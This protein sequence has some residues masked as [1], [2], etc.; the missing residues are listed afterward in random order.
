MR[1]VALIVALASVLPGCSGKSQAERAV[2]EI[3]KDPD[4]AKFGEFEVVDDTDGKGA[5]LVVN[6]KNSMGGYTGDQVA[7][8]IKKDGKWEAI[9]I[10]D[11]SLESCEYTM[12]SLAK[13]Q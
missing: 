8:L 11:T 6:A 3:L 12:K 5:C 13:S 10:S 9:D 1:K 4:S 7:S 2:R